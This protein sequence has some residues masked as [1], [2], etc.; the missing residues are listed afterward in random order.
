VVGERL[1]VAQR[2]LEGYEI[3][4][5]DNYD[6]RVVFSPSNWVVV[7]QEHTGGIIVL[8]V[9]KPDDR[10]TTTTE[11]STTSEVP[12][13]SEDTTTS[14]S[15]SEEIDATIFERA[16]GIAILPQQD[17]EN[18]EAELNP[19]IIRSGYEAE[20]GFLSAGVEVLIPYGDFTKD[21]ERFNYATTKPENFFM[22]C[23][24]ASGY[25]SW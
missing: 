17:Y 2:L 23:D 16:T 7:S 1:S 22:T 24:D 9:E 10:V 19:G 13:T 15:P 18:C 21:G 25:W 3:E 8:G 20:V 4:V 14:V 12:S 6:D 11:A 5:F